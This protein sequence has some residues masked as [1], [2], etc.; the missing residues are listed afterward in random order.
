M[1]TFLRQYAI[2][3]FASNIGYS[4][5]SMITKYDLPG[6]ENAEY[7]NL[8]GNTSFGRYSYHTAGN[9]VMNG[10]VQS[11]HIGFVEENVVDSLGV[12]DMAGRLMNAIYHVGKAGHGDI[13]CLE[14]YGTT[15]AGVFIHID[16]NDGSEYIHINVIGN[17][18]I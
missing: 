15:A 18:R 3:D 5:D 2:A 8:D 9:V 4:G 17:G 6:I 1:E 16:N 11:M 12:C 7:T 10:T 14:P 13:R